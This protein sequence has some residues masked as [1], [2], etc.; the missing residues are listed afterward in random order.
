MPS[1]RPF[2]SLGGMWSVVVVVVAGC[3][4]SALAQF[5]LPGADPNQDQTGNTLV[6]AAVELDGSAI[7]P[8]EPALLGVRYTINP[9]WHIYWSNAGDTGAPTELS[10][11]A[12]PGF[13]IGP[14]RWPRPE[15]FIEGGDTSFGYGKET[16]LFVPIVAPVDLEILVEEGAQADEQQNGTCHAWGTGRFAMRPRTR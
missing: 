7:V 3:F 11:T 2:S 13:K 14:I 16:M 8:G 15:I 5:K 1:T 10:V 4:S 12:P 6:K 9:A